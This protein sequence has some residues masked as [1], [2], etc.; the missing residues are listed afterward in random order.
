[1]N[2]FQQLKANAMWGIPMDVVGLHFKGGSKKSKSTSHVDMTTTNTH[3]QDAQYKNLL[4]GSDAWLAQG[5][6]DKN[7]G[8]YE[9]FDPIAGFTDEQRQGLSGM[10]GTG[11]GVQGVYGSLGMDA[12]RDSLGTYDP[13]KT[14]ITQALGAANEQMNYDFGT[15]IMPGVRQ[16]ASEV[17]QYGGS[18]HGIAEGLAL[19]RLAQ[20]QA[21]MGAQMAWQDQQAWNQQRQNTLNNLSGITEGLS[22]GDRLTYNAGAAQQGQ[23]QAELQGELERWAYEN[24][25]S[26][27]DLAAYKQMISGDMGSTARQHG[28]T[29]TTSTNSG[30]GGGIG[31]ALGSLGGAAAG[32]LFGGIGTSIGSQAGSQIGSKF[33]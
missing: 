8:G 16:G 29:S 9:D 31:G 22:S 24:N 30:G 19:G 11:Q 13:S 2:M 4:K 7:Y 10:A 1:M 33:L 23:N 32:S 18:R 15:Q 5:G 26:A 3:A 14:G 25:V 20:S 17:G 6:F 12:L 21:N 28:V 27:N